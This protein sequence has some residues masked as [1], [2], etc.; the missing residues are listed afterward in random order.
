[1]IGL[2]GTAQ[3]AD[4]AVFPL[5]TPV[6]VTRSNLQAMA[7]A[8][9]AELPQ[10][11]PGPVGSL[12]QALSDIFDVVN[13]VV[14]VVRV[15]TATGTVDAQLAE[16]VG[17]GA[18]K[19]G[20]YAL[21]NA[22]A[23]CNYKPKILIAPGYTDHQD[24]PQGGGPLLANPVATTLKT[25]AASLRAIAVIDGPNDTDEAALAKA[26]LEADGRLYPVDPWVTV[27]A[28]DGS[29]V[30]RPGSAFVAAII[31]LN[32]QVNGYWWSPSNQDFP[33]IVGT[34]RP[35]E[36]TMDDPTSSSNVLNGGNVATV[37]NVPG[38]GFKLWGNRT[39]ATDPAWAFLSV[40]RTADMIYDAMGAA[41]LWA[42]DRPFSAQLILDIENTGNAF[43]R[44]L[45][46]K[47]AILG[48]TLTLDPVLNTAASLQ[49]GQQYF[50]FDFEPP[51]PL[52]RLTL[53][54]SRN[55]DYLTETV[56]AALAQAQSA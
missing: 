18:A 19:T 37:V 12:G 15:E 1:V 9:T 7:T 38:G 43:L 49:A 39:G 10:N 52:E 36:F 30:T 3:Y 33:V 40:R 48:G 4:P 55:G 28:S 16:I 17:D 34:G 2:V 45:K 44:S 8:L 23:L 41:Y 11:N 22:Q 31:A 51:P 42:M 56:T 26:R 29:Y 35:I 20:C 32:D 53:T 47:G 14:V 5:D 13:A 25:V 6:S 21:R 50:D 46:A 27:L 24:A 54:A